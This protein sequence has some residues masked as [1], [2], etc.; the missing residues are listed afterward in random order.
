M[1]TSSQKSVIVSHPLVNS[2]PP[3]LAARFEPA[4][5]EYYN[6]YSAGRLATHQVPIG[7]FRKDPAK[8]TP[9]YG[10]QLVDQ[11]NL[12]ITDHQC[13]VDK[14]QGSII[15]RVFQPDPSIPVARPRPA[16]INHH[17]GGWVFGGLANDFDFCKRLSL[18]T[19]C[20]CFDVD[21]RLAPEY[22]YPIPVEDSWTAFN[23][24]R[25]HHEE[26]SIDLNRLAIGGC[27]AGGHLSAVTAISSRDAGIP[28]LLQILSMPICDLHVFSPTTSTLLPD[29]SY[30]SYREMYYSQ[31]L[32]AE[33]V[34]YFHKHFLG[35][36]SYEDGEWKVSPIR[37]RDF[38]GLAPAL[39][40]TAE[41]DPL[42]DEGEAYGK[43]LKDAG[44]TVE[45]HQI[46]GAPHTVM[47]MD[48][49]TEGGKLYNQI[50]VE[51]LKGAFVVK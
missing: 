22:P 14:P 48:D 51:A 21:Y 24:I 39:L 9:V 16:Y 3:E 43:K 12:V 18:E 33:R 20:V 36:K 41:M 31:P 29:Q 30:D 2:I 7:E 34:A 50:V 10:R 46:K 5:L 42:R 32:P 26:F 6:K 44:V 1:A 4:Y 27:S 25:D 47:Q 45:M 40:I 13:P 49:I 35:G 8:Y 17:G 11:G 28:V 38:Q 23:W 19:G 15:V 37:L